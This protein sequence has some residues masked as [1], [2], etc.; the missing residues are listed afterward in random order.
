MNTGTIISFVVVTGLL[1]LILKKQIQ[2]ALSQSELAQ[3]LRDIKTQADKG[4][5]EILSKIQ[6]LEDAINSAGGTTEEV[7]TALADLKSAVQ[8]IDDIVPDAPAPE[9][10][11]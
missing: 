11:G 6:A 10:E 2:M 8:G 9:P 4:K 7:D 3:Q 1:L 5:A